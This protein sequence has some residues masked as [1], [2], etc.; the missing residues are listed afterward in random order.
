MKN[1]EK[2]AILEDEIRYSNSSSITH[3]NCCY[4][5]ISGDKIKKF[6]S[7]LL[8]EIALYKGSGICHMCGRPIIWG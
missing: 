7:P 1:A 4:W 5:E 3:S 6:C 2:E 8:S